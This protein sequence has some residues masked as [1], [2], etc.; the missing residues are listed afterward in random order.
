MRAGHGHRRA[1]GDRVEQ[2]QVLAR[3]LGRGCPRLALIEP[4][5]VEQR[6][7]AVVSRALVLGDLDLDEQAVI[8]IGRGRSVDPDVAPRRVP[9]LPG[10][11][12]GIPDADLIGIPDPLVDHCAA[13]AAKGAPRHRQRR[14]GS[15]ELAETC[16]RP[17][18]REFI[19]PSPIFR[20][21][22]SRGAMSGPPTH[23]R[24]RRSPL[25]KGQSG[26]LTAER[27]EESHRGIP[28]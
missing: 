8:R 14:R 20:S 23:N 25:G 1:V 11:I 10:A 17:S 26:R 3:L 2:I 28:G 27:D 5:V 22:A 24:Q 12:A 19:A 4:V 7:A 18:I 6:L 16:R 9:R 15:T 13:A 21:H